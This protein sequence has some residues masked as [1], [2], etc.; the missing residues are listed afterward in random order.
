MLTRRSI[1]GR[2][3]AVA[4]AAI[5]MVGV[6]AAGVTNAVAKELKLSYF[7]SPKH[8]M[9]KAVFTPFSERLEALSGGALTVK[10][11]P[12]GELG[13]GPQQQY[14]RAVDGV[15]EVVFGIPGYTAKIFPRTMLVA[16]P[17][18]VP[19]AIDGTE[20]LWGAKNYLDAEFQNVKLL[21]M[22]SNEVAVLI[23]RDKPVRSLADVKG[24]KIRAPSAADAPFIKAWGAI[25]VQ[26]PVSETYNALS[27]GVVDA[28]MIGS[29]GI[30]SFKLNEPAKYITT[31][32]PASAAAFYLVMNKGVW[33]GLTAEEQGWVDAASGIELSRG[34]GQAYDAAGKRGLKLA[35]EGGVEIIVLSEAE[36]A[37]FNEVSQPEVQKV[38]DDML[39][40]GIP[41]NAILEDMRGAVGGS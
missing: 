36:R 14:K 3:A 35:A 40:D 17:G 30:G 33:E 22:W 38:I 7:M 4:L 39:A 28:V 41:A 9:N 32:L 23:T 31:N 1:N 15:A 19:N 34:G 37:M 24:M 21:A 10:Q 18:V 20:M 8:P 26:M 12:A 27:N 11:F 29:S 5:A 16:L 2:F 25:P 6:G 13:K